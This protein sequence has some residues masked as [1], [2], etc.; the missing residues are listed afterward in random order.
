MFPSTFGRWGSNGPDPSRA[1]PCRHEQVQHARSTG[2]GSRAN[3]PQWKSPLHGYNLLALGSPKGSYAPPAGI[4]YF[5][6]HNVF[7]KTQVPGTSCTLSTSSPSL[8][9]FSS[10]L[11]PPGPLS[12]SS[13]NPV[14]PWFFC[15]PAPQHRLPH[16][17]ASQ[18][19]PP[20]PLPSRRS[21]AFPTRPSLLGS[22]RQTGSFR[23]ALGG[24][25]PR[26]RDVHVPTQRSNHLHAQTR[27]PQLARAGHGHGYTSSS[28]RGLG[29]GG[30]AV[31]L[32]SARP[33]AP[34]L[35]HPRFVLHSLED[36]MDQKVETGRRQQSK[37]C[38]C[39]GRK[40]EEHFCAAGTR[41]FPDE[42]ID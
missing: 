27:P 25:D 13:V 15:S 4:V 31:T 24:H 14:P 26:A 1:T 8:A 19:I 12:R 16:R 22:A 9:S 6:V 17:A 7:C 33:L 30:R 2:G 23:I 21:L 28:R 34:R 3:G 42:G 32:Q 36:H 40:Q 10:L 39:L 11:L 20:V 29:E 5:P 35:P 38:E 41:V 18:P 37:G